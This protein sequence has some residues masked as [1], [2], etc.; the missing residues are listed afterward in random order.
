M[1]FISLDKWVEIMEMS[2]ACGDELM[3]FALNVLY[4]RHTV[5]YNENI[6]WT[7]VN[8][9]SSSNMDVSELHDIYDVHLVFLGDYIFGELK[10]KPMLPSP[11][12]HSP[13]SLVIKRKRGRL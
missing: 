3:L 4:C 2:T 1:N 10:R 13:P 8:D 12:Y 6:V 5:V 11:V 7:T 9:A